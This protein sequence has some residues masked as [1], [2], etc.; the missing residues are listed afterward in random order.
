MRIILFVS[1]V[2]SG[3][4]G[5]IMASEMVGRIEEGVLKATIKIKTPVGTFGSGFIVSKPLSG[6]KRYSFLVTNKHLIGNYLRQ[7]VDNH[8]F[9]QS[10]GGISLKTYQYW[11]RPPDRVW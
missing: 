10:A 2:M 7:D 11:L 9:P 4:N 8:I 6:G 3:I 5:E 1:I